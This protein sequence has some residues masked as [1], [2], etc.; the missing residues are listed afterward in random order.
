M[1]RRRASAPR[2][3]DFG[4]VPAENTDR[5]S[6]AQ[7]RASE[8]PEKV[9]YRVAPAEGGLSH[10]Y[11]RARH[12]RPGTTHHAAPIERS[13]RRP[14]RRPGTRRRA[15]ASRRRDRRAVGPPRRR[16][17]TPARPDPRV[18]CPRRLEQWL[19]LLRRVADLARRARP[20]RRARACPRRARSGR[21]APP[22]RRPRPRRTVVLQGPRAD[23]RG[24]A[25]HRGA[26]P[27]GGPGRHGGARRADRARLA[28]SRPPGRGSRGSAAAREPGATRIS[29]Q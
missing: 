12:S 22:G 16:D 27:G 1:L 9:G 3:A 23:A 4:R 5:R 2:Q 13:V 10:G 25:G 21:F 15:G 6:I 20:G 11:R 18:R 29:G 19:P 8:G 17:R 24:H 26:A 28:P 14:S 7:R